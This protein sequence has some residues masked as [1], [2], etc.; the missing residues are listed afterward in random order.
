MSDNDEWG[1]WIDHDGR[2]CPVPRGTW[3]EGEDV[4]G[5]IEQWAAMMHKKPLGL[6]GDAWSWRFRRRVRLDDIIRYRIRKPRGLTILEGLLENLP[7]K[8]DA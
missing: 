2:G 3:V 1:P 6:P 5:H 8:V 7:S 4:C